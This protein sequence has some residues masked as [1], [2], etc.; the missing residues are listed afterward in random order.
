MGEGYVKKVAISSAIR[1]DNDIVREFL[2]SLKELNKTKVKVSYCFIDD[3]SDEKSSE[4]IREFK[5]SVDDV[6]ILEVKDK[7]YYK[8]SFIGDHQ[9]SD[10]MINKIA[11]YKNEI[12]KW[13]LQGDGEY[14]FFVDSDLIL[15]KETLIT[16]LESDKD[17]IS[18]IF[19]TAWG[20]DG[21]E[22][23][24]VW[25]VDFYTMFKANM[26]RRITPKEAEAEA[27]EFLA[28]LR[29]GGVYKVG[30]LGA[31]TLIK[32]EP[33]EKGV[34]FSPIYN[35]SFWGEDRHFCIRAVAYGYELF[36][37]TYHPSLHIYRKSDLEKINDFKNEIYNGSNKIVRRVREENKITLSMVLKNEGKRY[38]REF[39]QK[40]REIID[41]AVIIDDGSIDDT[42][43]IVKEILEG[44]PFKLIQNNKSLFKN[45]VELRKLQ[46][47][48]TIKTDPDWILNLDGDEVFEDEFYNSIRELIK[49]D[50]NNDAYCFRLYDFWDENHYREDKEW[51]AH[52]YYRPFLVRY[53][54]NFKYIFRNT[55]QHCGRFPSNVFQLE[56]KL[57]N[58]R[59]K[60]FGWAK[61]EDRAEKY[62]RYMTLDP[63]G[64]YGNI[65]QYLS[66]LD[67]DPNLILWDENSR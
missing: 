67:T 26:L 15:H 33:L 48:E 4:Y 38:L 64:K 56:N 58:F 28:K 37:N 41:S 44:I 31:C 47:E 34:D 46:W 6:T 12:I 40:H 14:L 16:L 36:V 59:L 7:E 43:D 62:K 60:H 52:K 3:N 35:V 11:Y 61:V 9:W 49:S 22:H 45:E 27:N 1:K 29:V 57:S 51:R 18:N 8:N 53:Q 25:Q 2:I 42:L 65:N 30:G 10:G 39:L 55:S 63:M 66:I 17:I 19:W 32:R 5:D 21:I 23:P 50:T 20:A 54:P 13:F 24:Q